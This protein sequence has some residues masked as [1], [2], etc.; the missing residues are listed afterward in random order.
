MEGDGR[1]GGG[2]EYGGAGEA[3]G[4]GM[5]QGDQCYAGVIPHLNCQK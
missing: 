5:V 4:P 2:E 1:A 3:V